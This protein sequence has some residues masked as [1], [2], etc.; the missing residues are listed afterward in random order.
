MTRLIVR[1]N[2]TIEKLETLKEIV[3]QRKK[4]DLKEYEI[5]QINKEIGRLTKEEKKLNK[6][7]KKASE[8]KEN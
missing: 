6:K 3:N 1:R 5:L 2:N 4:N 8:Y 7:I